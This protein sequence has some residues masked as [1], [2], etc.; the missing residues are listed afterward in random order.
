[1]SMLAANPL[2]LQLVQLAAMKFEDRREA[3]K[4]HRK[5]AKLPDTTKRHPR[6]GIDAIVLHAMGFVRNRSRPDKFD[7]VK[8]HFAVLRSGEILYLHDVEEYLHA[9]HDFNSRSISIEFE[10][11]PPGTDGKAHA[12]AKLGAHVPTLQQIRSG[13]NLVTLL[14]RSPTLNLRYIYGHRQSCAK[15]CPGP[16]IWYNVGKWATTALRLSDGGPGYTTSNKYC[17]GVGIPASWNDAQYDLLTTAG[18]PAA[19]GK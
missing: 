1:M 5:G 14:A 13:R 8:A 17:A 16:H 18:A 15:I 7:G 3:V 9:A 6:S 2:V 19:A 4:K 12:E 10:G 11:N